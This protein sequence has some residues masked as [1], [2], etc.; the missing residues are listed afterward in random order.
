MPRPKRPTKEKIMDAA[1]KLFARRGFHGT[2][3]RAITGA[4]GVDLA[5]VNYHFGSKKLLLAAII[6]RRG[7]P[8]NEERLRRLAEE[9]LG[10]GA[11]ARGAR[12]AKYRSSSRRLLRSY[13]GSART[14][15]SWLAQ[16]LLAARICE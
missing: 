3:V 4:A 13:S 2:S 6:E 16:L 12:P 10:G 15:R 8:L 5:L 7:Q 9:R 11:P 1:E 14:R